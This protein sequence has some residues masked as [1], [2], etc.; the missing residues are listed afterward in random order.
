[1]QDIELLQ[2]Q[3]QAQLIIAIGYLLE[4]TASNQ[5]I[6]VIL[7]RIAE[8]NSDK[9][10]GNFVNE[11]EK[12]EEA[13]KTWR[14]EGLDADK[15]AV[16]AAIFELYGQTFL[17][18]INYIKLQRLPENISRMDLTLTKTANTE[19]FYGSVLELM[20]YILNYRGVSILYAISNE[21]ATFD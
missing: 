16:I 13:E 2:T 20:A 1:M 18:A 11:E 5:A 4:Y 10:S 8:R 3:S 14:N 19:I 9:A 15:T 6:E 7:A 21:N 17:T 12:L